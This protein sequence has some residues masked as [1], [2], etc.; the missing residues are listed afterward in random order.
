MGERLLSE[1]VSGNLHKAYIE[2]L[3]DGSGLA[4]YLDN[5]KERG[6]N[7]PCCYLRQ[8]T[9]IQ[10]NTM[11]LND[12]QD[13]V[14]IMKTYAM[15][16]QSQKTIAYQIDRVFDDDNE[17][18]SVMTDDGYRFYLQGDTTF[19]KSSEKAS[20]VGHWAK[21]VQSHIDEA[22]RTGSAK[23]ASLALGQYVGYCLDAKAREKQHGGGRGSSTSWLSK[24]FLAVC[25][26]KWPQKYAFK[27]LVIC[28]IF[29]E[30][31]GPWMEVLLSRFM[32][33]YYVDGGF[34]IA[35]AGISTS[36]LGFTKLSSK[37]RSEY[38]KDK[39][40]W[41]NQHTQMKANGLSEFHRRMSLLQQKLATAAAP[42]AAKLDETVARQREHIVKIFAKYQK[43]IGD[44][45][46]YTEMAP[47]LVERINKEYEV[48]RAL[49]DAHREYAQWK[50]ACGL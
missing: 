48:A 45:D 2:S 34:S 15:F 18:N 29:S 27:F 11:P 50:V 22:K 23:I 16:D 46:L 49:R 14:S 43:L 42:V 3:R 25:E 39:S 28:M 7:H 13:V 31:T 20:V 41:V 38:W 30:Y 47:K 36:S 33:A 26:V 1:A 44:P 17:W 5:L 19:T 6:E 32:R 10:G 12:L 35:W 8:L 40:D 24:L 4:R 21:A 37:E 9:D